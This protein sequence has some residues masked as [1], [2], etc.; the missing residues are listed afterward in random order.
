MVSKAL[1]LL[2]SARESGIAITVNEKGELQ[3]KFSKGVQIAPKLL[4]DLKDNKDLITSFLTDNKYKS[5]KVE[6]FE[7]ELRNIDRRAVSEIPARSLQAPALV[8]CVA[9]HS[10]ICSPGLGLL[11]HLKT[12]YLFCRFRS[13][14]FVQA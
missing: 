10:L 6:A 8:L 7:N 3:L 14:A 13:V 4:Q 2:K 12:F 9:L 1:D 11:F 5:R